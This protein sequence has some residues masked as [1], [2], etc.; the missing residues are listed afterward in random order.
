MTADDITHL[1]LPRL[2][3]ARVRRITLTG[4]EPFLHPK[5]IEICRAIVTQDIPVGIC[6]NATLLTS[7]HVDE[8]ADLGRVHVNVSFDGFRPAS[9]GRFRGNVASFETTVANT[10]RLAD[11]GL[12]QGLLSTPN[13]L[14]DV[15]EYAE[16]CA[17]ALDVGAEYLLMN[18]L[19]S[20]GR[21][22]SSIGRLGA[23]EETMRAIRKAT[24]RFR[25][26]GLDLTYIRF[27]N[28]DKPLSP[29][30]AGNIIYVFTDGA[31][32][33]CPYLVFAARTPR[34]Q[35]ETDEFLVGN[36][37]EED[38]AP[39]LEAYD[40]NSRHQVG[41]NSVC[42]SCAMSAACGKGCPAVVVAAGG[43]IGGLDTDQCPVAPGKR[44]S[45]PLTV[46]TRR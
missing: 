2:E 43:R 9:H 7:R 30:E 41:S 39:A 46:K 5:L 35:Y 25:E 23:S 17:F 12:L 22:V 38:V 37:F 14:N 4:G 19:S 34:S 15:A 42:S 36:I 10:R 27:P 29:C 28:D 45:L 24:E 8:L 26:A 3:A 6:T 21:G 13:T 11:A 44:T 33:V 16:L 1:L 31:T 20:F 18:P 40:V 32:A